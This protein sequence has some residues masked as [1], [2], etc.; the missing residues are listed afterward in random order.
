MGLHRILNY[1]VQLAL[2]RYFILILLFLPRTGM[3]SGFSISGG[4]VTIANAAQ[5]RT[6]TDLA[7]HSGALN[8]NNSQIVIGGNWA[9]TG[10]SFSPGTSTVTFNSTVSGRTIASKGS[11][12]YNL[13]FNGSGG[14]WT[15]QDSMTVLSTMTL[16]AGTLDTNSGN[17]NPLSLGGGWLN[18]GG[19]FT[20]NQSTVTLVGNTAQVV[21]NAG[22]AF[23]VIL[24]SNTSGGG[25]VFASSFTAAALTINGAGLASPT[26]VYFNANST[27]TVTSLT[28]IGA[29]GQRVWIRSTV[30]NQ[31]WFLNNTSTNNVTY[32]DVKD[33]NAGA[34]Q[35]IAAGPRS[36]DQGNNINWTFLIL[37]ISLS[38]HSYDFG[39]V[40]MGVTTISTSAVTITNTGN[41][42]ETYSLSV[43]TTGAKT[44]WG[45]GASTPTSLDTLV[46]F[47][48][49]NSVQPSSNTFTSADVVTGNPNTA[50]GSVYAGNETAVSVPVGIDR[51]LWMRLDMPL[52][53]STTDQQLLN[54]TAT[55]SSP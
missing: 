36:I 6:V 11:P 2:R 5:L 54:L 31:Q 42:T 26:T 28:M 16:S 17:S 33:S 25:V 40:K 48:L 50:T 22:Q 30:N 32:V 27:Y 14:Y 53:T 4:T 49:F 29:S 18:N 37:S 55:A 21:Q 47:N 44:I 19:T 35:T 1:S 38:T 12:F 3:C 51:H 8:A 7:I 10:G 20:V 23:S 41:D 39:M 9:N 13:Y 52:Y 34:G 45:V 24:D 15:L 46:F 43:A